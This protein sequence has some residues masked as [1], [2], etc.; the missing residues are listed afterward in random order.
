MKQYED[1]GPNRGKLIDWW[2]AYSSPPGST[3]PNQKE[4][5]HE[6]SSSVHLSLWVILF[7]AILPVMAMSIWLIGFWGYDRWRKCRH[8]V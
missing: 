7:N 3:R 5:L 6:D 8:A 2:P 4:S 1:E